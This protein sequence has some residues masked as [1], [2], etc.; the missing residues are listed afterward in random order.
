[1]TDHIERE[2]ELPAPPSDVWQALIDPEWLALWL[3]DEVEM[4]LAPGGEARFRIG[5]DVRT[6]WIEEVTPPGTADGLEPRIARLA[7]W[8]AADP[9]P[10]SRVEIEL[11]PL[12]D[13]TTRLRLVEA[14]PLEILDLVGLPLPGYGSTDHGPALLARC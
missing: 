6:G 14:R 9:E 5:D 11:M 4:E 13:G 12:P 1:M 7:F 8:W 2:L 10:A 3:A